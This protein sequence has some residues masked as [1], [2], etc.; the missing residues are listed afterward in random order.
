MRILVTGGAGYI[1]SHAI[2]TL[3]KA[4]HQV[5]VL[6]NLANGSVEA[7]K[8]ASELGDAEVP[9]VKSDARN[10][11]TLGTLFSENAFDVVTCCAG[12]EGYPFRCQYLE[13]RH[14]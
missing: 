14:R 5:V 7:D 13:S 10:R 6:D 3:L 4:G 2:V 1:G 9:H 8:R 12:G 11:V